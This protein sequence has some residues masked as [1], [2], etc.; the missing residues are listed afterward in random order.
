MTVTLAF[1]PTVSFSSVQEYTGHRLKFRE[2]LDGRYGYVYISKKPPFR[3]ELF[4][5]KEDVDGIFIV[6]TIYRWDEYDSRI[7]DEIS[8]YALNHILEGADIHFDFGSPMDYDIVNDEHW[9]TKANA[10]R[11]ATSVQTK[12]QLKEAMDLI[13]QKATE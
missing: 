13:I 11:I 2:M 3:L 6:Y 4:R 5:G 9:I 1:L 10:N 8:L 7:T 12:E